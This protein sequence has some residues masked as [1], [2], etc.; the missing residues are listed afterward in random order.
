MRSL[1]IGASGQVGSRLLR[2]ARRQGDCLGTYRSHLVPGLAPLDLCDGPAIAA[3]FRDFKP[4]VCYLPAA[5]THVDRAQSHQEECRAVN[6]AGVANVIEAVARSGSMLVFLS[7]DHVFSDRDRPWRE[8]EPTCPLSVYAASKVAA[9]VAIRRDLPGRHLIVR[10]S[11]VFGPD[12]QEKNF[13]YRVRR[14][15]RSGEMLSVRPGEWGQPTYGPDLARTICHMVRRRARGTIHVV[16]PEPMTRIS[17]AYLL[18]AEMGLS[19]QNIT[20]DWSP[21]S[22]EIAP[23]PL[24][25]QLSR[26]RLLRYLGSD[27]IRVP[28]QGIRAAIRELAMAQAMES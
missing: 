15:L 17:W 14:T 5:F 7:T 6:Q 12:V 8:L 11:W 28:R 26:A 23:R 18:A 16:G 19:T 3:L 1:I 13:L 27:P 9:E 4:Q 10:T 24:R 20:L 21:P 2:Y 25:V 22:I